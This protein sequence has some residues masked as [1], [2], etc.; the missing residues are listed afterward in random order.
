MPVGAVS[1]RASELPV[2]AVCSRASELPVGA[3][4]NRASSRCHAGRRGFQPRIFPVS[5]R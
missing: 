3:V 5:S 4:S 2:G 1:N